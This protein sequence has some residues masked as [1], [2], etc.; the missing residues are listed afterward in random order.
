MCVLNIGLNNRIKNN[1]KRKVREG[2][3]GFGG[4]IHLSIVHSSVERNYCFRELCRS[5]EITCLALSTVE[6][7]ANPAMAGNLW[8]STRTGLV[9]TP[10]LVFIIIGILGYN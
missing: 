2:S 10:G 1:V 8:L 3:L 7:Q 4:S 5:A 6:G 9:P